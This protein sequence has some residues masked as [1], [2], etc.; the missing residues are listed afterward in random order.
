MEG[1]R[2]RGRGAAA[3]TAEQ[4]ERYSRHLLIPEV[5]VEGQQKLLDAKVLLLGAGGLGSP[6]ALYLAAAGVGH[7]RHR[8]R[9]RGRP[10]E[11]AA[12]GDPHHRPHRR[13]Q[14]RLG[15]G[16]DPRAQPRRRGGQVPV[17]LDASNIVEIIEGYDVDRRRPRQLPD[18][19]PAQRR[20]GA[21][22]H[23]GRLGRDPRLRRAAVGVQALRRPVL[24]LPVPRAAAGRAG[25]VVRRQR[26]AGRAARHHGPAQATEV[27]QAHHRRRR[28]A[29]RPPAALRRARRDVH[30]G[31]GP[32][33]PRVPD[34]LARR[35]RRSPTTSWASS[36]TTRRSAPQ[37]G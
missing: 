23:P 20:V 21:P 37:P 14:G 35:P 24:P 9:R 31:Q 10:V 11:P 30:R 3:L 36:R 15:R 8:R 26:R 18:A 34:L 29:H 25:A 6:T 22:A 33:R 27:G 12:P 16:D 32:P 1:P 7:A 19:L 17:R 28:P 4:R 13:A 5:G 2:L